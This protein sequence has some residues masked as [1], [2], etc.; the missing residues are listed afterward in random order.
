MRKLKAVIFDLDNTLLDRTKTFR[1][2]AS[3]WTER[4]FEHV[5][6]AARITERVIELDEDGYKDKRELFRELLEELPWLDKPELDELMDDYARYYVSHA[7]L[8]DH[9]RETIGQLR[10][11]YRIGLITNGRTAIQYGK[12]DRLGIRE[13]FDFILVSEEAGVKKPH[14]AI[15]E[16]AL[17]RLGVSADECV[18]VG[19]HPKNDIEGA[20]KAG[21]RTIW[22]EVNQ[23]WREEIAVLPGHR[24]KQLSELGGILFGDAPDAK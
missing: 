21:L 6:D 20:G 3:G 2:F 4:Y 12:I 8:M 5:A 24:I 18:Y 19:D 1:Q 22:M 10:T 15:F 13:L 23:P 16:L 9:A 17:E 14:A 11:A 7:C